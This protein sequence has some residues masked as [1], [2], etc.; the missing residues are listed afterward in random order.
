ML[1]YDKTCAPTKKK[2]THTHTRT[3]TRTHCIGELFSLKNDFTS[4]IYAF[5]ASEQSKYAGDVPSAIY[6]RRRYICMY[7][8]E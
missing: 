1:M 8:G 2:Y 3:H 5:N 4:I 7:V 6:S